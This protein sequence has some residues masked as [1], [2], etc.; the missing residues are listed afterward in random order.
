ML[1][2]LPTRFQVQFL[3]NKD[4][5]GLKIKGEASAK[6]PKTSEV[7]PP[8]S[9][10]WSQ[11]RGVSPVRDQGGCGSCWAFAAVAYGESKLLLDDR[12]DSI[13][14]AEQR[15]LECTS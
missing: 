15:L 3:I 10:D 2:G 7:A 4:L 9:L 11:K 5:K 1:L 13:D 8:S 14:L 6:S 12:Y